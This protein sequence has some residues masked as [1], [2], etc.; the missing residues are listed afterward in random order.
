MSY[1][2]NF[3]KHHELV[4]VLAPTLQENS[5]PKLSVPEAR[6]AA[7]AVIDI[8]VPKICEIVDEE[9]AAALKRAALNTGPG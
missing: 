9:I 6:M 7:S 8:L 4:D 1:Q 5:Y 2:L 3:Q